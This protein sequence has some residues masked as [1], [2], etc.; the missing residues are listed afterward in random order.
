MEP[1]VIIH[2]GVSLDGR[3]DYSK[4]KDSPYY[5]IV[6]RLKADADLSG[7][8]TM[9][10][11]FTPDDPQSAFGVEYDTWI[12]NPKRAMLVVVDSQAQIKNWSLIIRQPWWRDHIAFCSQAT[13]ESHL[14]YL[15]DLGVKTIVH[16]QHNVDLRRALNEL[17]LRFGVNTVRVDSGGLLN[18]VLLRAGLVSQVS[19]VIN[20]ELVGGISPRSMFVA[21]DLTSELGVIPLKLQHMENIRGDY[22]WL[23][24]KVL[25]EDI[26]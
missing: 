26:A 8:R 4:L 13:P 2:I 18:G 19:V 10:N 20:P 15:K 21:S 6:P 7:S 11:S 1:N 5:E 9:L 17:H 12:N 16:G 14:E 25:E 23:V 24:Y 22:V 3:I